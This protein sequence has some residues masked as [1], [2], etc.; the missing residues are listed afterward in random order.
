MITSTMILGWI[1]V[2]LFLIIILTFKSMTKKNEYAFLHLLMAI[3][4]AMWFPLPLALNHLIESDIVLVGTV[5]GFAYLFL[6][7][8]S[9][10]LQTGHIAFIEKHD[11]EHSI[12]EKHAEYMMATLTKPFESFLGVFKSIWAIFL[13]ISF[14][15]S[16]ELLMAGLMLLFGLFIFYYLFISIDASL[17]KRVKLFS[18]VKPN[19]FIV[20]LETLAFFITLMCYVTYRSFSL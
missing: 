12:P 7:V 13:G 5:F 6:L 4:Y 10:V 2:L 14:W 15:Q 20:N 11:K 16:G 18:K 9:M 3:M 19:I 8:S 1:G 17:M